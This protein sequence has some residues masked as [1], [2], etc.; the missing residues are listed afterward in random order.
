MWLFMKI[1]KKNINLNWTSYNFCIS[2]LIVKYGMTKEEF[3]F[4]IL[5]SQLSNESNK[6]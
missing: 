6:L 4:A 1:E 2:T 5:V 3:E